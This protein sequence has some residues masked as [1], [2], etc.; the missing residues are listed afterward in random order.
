MDPMQQ[1]GDATNPLTAGAAPQG[2]PSPQGGMAVL[3]GHLDQAQA[4]LKVA[5]KAAKHLG[6]IKGELEKLV[7][8]GDTVTQEDVVEGAGRLVAQ[9]LPELEIAGL[10]ADMP[11][12]SQALQAWVAG[13][14]QGVVM[15]EAKLGPAHGLARHET[16]MAALRLITAHAVTPTMESPAQSNDLQGPSAGPGNDLSAASPQGAA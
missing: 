1:Q 15:N 10:L 8:M 11:E 5:D 6:I 12:N 9:G 2:A 16:G 7:M 3:Q 14:L 13:H 4:R